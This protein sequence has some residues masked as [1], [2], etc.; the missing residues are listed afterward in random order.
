MTE[1]KKAKK[2]VMVVHP[3]FSLGHGWIKDVLEES[4]IE[5][6][7]LTH[8]SIYFPVADSPLPEGAEEADLLLFY[9][10]GG[11]NAWVEM[12]NRLKKP[13]VYWALGWV[14]PKGLVEGIPIVQSFRKVVPAIFKA[15]GRGL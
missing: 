6:E 15:I 13:C 2:V 5:F 1:E 8:Q 9:G 11:Q 10:P 7:V 4:G 12:A 14:R 3:E